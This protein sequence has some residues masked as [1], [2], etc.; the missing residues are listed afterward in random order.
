MP[1]GAGGSC[2]AATT[3]EI[4]GYL[5][6][7][8]VAL[9]GMLLIRVFLYPRGWG[10]RSVPSALFAIIGLALSLPLASYGS[11]GLALALAA[12][13]ILLFPYRYFAT[14]YMKARTRAGLRVL[15]ERWGTR[16]LQDSGGRWDVIQEEAGRKKWVGNVLTY[17]GSIDPGVKRREVGYMLAFVI[18][19]EHQPAFQCSFMMGWDSPRYFER[20]WRATHVIHGEFLSLPF[21]DLGLAQDR[22]RATGGNARDLEPYVQ[23]PD[24]DRTV[25]VVGTHPEAFARVF[26]SDSL[27]ELFQIA[28]Q[29]FPFELNVSPSSVSIYTTYCDA[30]VQRANLEFLE[31]LADR[32]EET[33]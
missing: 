32:L 19:L 2:G 3:E 10:R 1:C 24:T 33:E 5:L 12:A 22:G 17:K 31:Q 26:D 18:E 8:S 6:R 9:I 29:T 28:A 7:V 20:E 16:L 4:M 27:A 30:D 21:G 13:L 23:L 14:R 11:T 25:A 15:A